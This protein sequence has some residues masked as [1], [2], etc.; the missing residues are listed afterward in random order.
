MT[1]TEEVVYRS[2]LA[3]MRE[4]QRSHV[5]ETCQEYRDAQKAKEGLE[6]NEETSSTPPPAASSKPVN[7]SSSTQ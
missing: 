6:D 4:E 3:D 7:D 1:D 2:A 5:R